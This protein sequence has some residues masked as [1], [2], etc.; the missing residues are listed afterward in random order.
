MI[1][2]IIFDVG[3]VLVDFR[4]LAYMADLGFS[5]EL[6]MEF[7]KK[8]VWNPLWQELDRGVLDPK[9]VM[10]EMKK[11]VPSHKKEADLFFDR[12]DEIVESFPYAQEWLHSLRERG[13][14]TYLLSNYPKDLFEGHVENGRFTFMKDIDGKVVSAYEKCIK[15]DPAIYNC[16]LHRYQLQ[17]SE[18]VFL[19]DRK[20]NVEAAI[21][22]GIHGIHFT[23]YGKC[24]AQ[25]EQLLSE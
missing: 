4:D 1:K 9:E 18:C 3:N 19:D 7:Q 13:Y 14:K 25:L 11:L 15:P 17:P 5:E 24:K 22:L 6:A 12:L 8:V 21:A 23:D 20:E 10:E 2:N 16:L